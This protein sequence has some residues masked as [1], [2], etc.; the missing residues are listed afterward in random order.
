MTRSLTTLLF[1]VCCVFSLIAQQPDTFGKISDFEKKLVSY[2]KDPSANALVLHERGDNY[3]KVIDNYVRL[4]KEYHVKIKILNQEGFDWGTVEIP[5]YHRGT[6]AEKITKLRAVTHNGDSQYNV[7][8]AEIFTEDYSERWRIKKF[9][10]PKLQKGSIL[11]YAYTL[12][13]PYDYK[14]DGWEFQSSIPKLYSEFNA[15]IPGNWVYNRALIG[16]LKLHMNDSHLK[17][18]CLHIKGYG[19]PADCEVLK[20]SMKDIPAFKE[21]KDFMLAS[22]NYKARLDFEISQ[23]NRFDG[24]SR[25]YTKSWKDVD[26]EFRSDKD[27]GRQ[28]TKKGFFERNVP[29]K[30]L[31]EGSTMERA[32]NIY[33]FIQGHY[34]WNGESSTY[35]QARVK[36]AFEAKKGNAWEINMSLINL[37]NAA[38]IP[39]NLMLLSTRQ[40][41]LPK[42]I[43][44]VM[45][46]FN[47]IVAKVK[48]DG[49]DYLLDATDKYAPFGLLPFRALNHYG[50]VMDF[51]N[52]SYWQDILPEGKNIKQ[53]RG[54]IRFNVEN[55]KAEG[56]LDIFSTGYNA[57]YKRKSMDQKTKEEYLDEFEE[58]IAGEFNING[59]ELAE[60]RSDERKVSERLKFEIEDVLKGDKLYFNPFLVQ[61]FESNPFKL[62]TRDYPIDFGY[63]RAYRY[64]MNV[65][66]PPGYKV[67]ELPES[68]A[69]NLGKSIVDLRFYVRQNETQV[70]IEYH[71]ALRSTHFSP[72]DYTALKQI[73]SKAVELQKNSLIVLE[74]TESK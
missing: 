54:Q 24:T 8:P 13:T 2:E 74:K 25:R 62:E 1:S 73:F 19:K 21:E 59:Y 7:L 30:L 64:Q 44:P 72:E 46:D 50:R 47:Y 23:Y 58:G 43:H 52:E 3:F 70:G 41:G 9:T 10:F 35:G 5:L 16:S 63:P 66:I 67:I 61:F 45:S 57:V 42:K 49:K 26:K 56:V 40:R 27:I 60:D 22:K 11:E 34:N 15:K 18:G 31:T 4:V 14:L 17:K 20:Y 48:I 55:Q 29:E 68:I 37:L 38:D 69:V 6:S 51:K 32:N 53:A 33:K 36:D 39:A 65:T 28:L 71:L 12:V